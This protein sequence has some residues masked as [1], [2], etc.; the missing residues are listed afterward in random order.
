MYYI[1]VILPLP[2]KGVFTYCSNDMLIIGQR[3]VVQ[4]GARKL[5][6]AVVCRVHQNCPTNYNPKDILSIIDEAPIVNQKQL[7]LWFWISEY[8]MCNV[9]DVMNAALPSLFKLTSTSKIIIHTDYDGDIDHLDDNE[10][11]I[12]NAL[13]FEKELSVNTVF[14]LINTSKVFSYINHLIRKDVI[15]IKEE[16]ND[17]YREKKIRFIKCIASREKLANTIFTKK[18]KILLDTFLNLQ[19]QHSKKRFKISELL[20]TTK[21]SRG[22]FNVLVKKGIFAMEEIRVSRIISHHIAPIKDKTLS[23]FQTKALKGIQ[24]SFTQKD[25]CLLHGVTSSGKTE[26]Y[27]KLIQEQLEKGKQIL[28]LLP[29][30]A[31]TTQIIKRLRSHFGNKV[32]TTHSHISNSERVEVWRAVQEKENKKLSY[33][34]IIGARSSL[35]LPFDNLGLIIVDEE[36]DMS[37]KQQNPAPRYHARDTAIYLA[38]LHKSKVLLGSATPCLETFYNVSKGKFSLVEMHQRFA[39]IELPDIKTVDIRKAYLKKQMQYHFSTNLIESI[40]VSLELGKQVILFQNRRGYSPIIS[41][42]DCSYTPNCKNCDVSLTY[43]KWNNSLKCHYC[44]YAE[45]IPNECP[46]CKCKEFSDEGF[47]TEQIEE[48]LGQLF[49]NYVAKRLDYDTTR[50]K[51]A[52]QKII[53]D[54]EQGKIDILVGTQMVTKGLDFDNVSLVG[55]LNA[56]S[57]FNFPDFR[58]Y[59][60]AFQLLVQVSGR[61]GRKEM[62][63]KVLVQTFDEEKEIFSLLKEYNY[64]T[65]IKN[66]LAERKLFLYPPYARLIGITLKHKNQNKLDNAAKKLA[67]IMRNSFG[68]RVLGPEY[69]YISKIRNYYHKNLLLKIENKSSIRNA[70][71]ILSMILDNFSSHSEFK[72][73]RIVVDVDLL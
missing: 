61:A 27:I 24:H 70:K 12:V 66:Q 40:S 34:V 67:L 71:Q 68:D 60:K 57:M 45:E 73:I 48:G 4:F 3:V 53:S 16:L 22:V 18:Q 54:F 31:L 51:H 36:H 8:Y 6:T 13:L 38:S 47:G 2:V 19:F 44:G 7:D 21:L 25:V 58:S 62:K 33:P 52:Y 37:Y 10:K 20:D 28:Y 23:N 46:S 50:R 29:E 49:P 9:G 72:S 26:L 59:E 17:K 42:V 1:D 41:C 14:K 64:K 5:Y 30:I 15:Q 32:G 56:D 39:H 43:Y 65:F 35:F 55:I 63:G 11:S 69:P